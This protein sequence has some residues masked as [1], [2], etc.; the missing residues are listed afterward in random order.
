M[1][2]EGREAL[3]M[4][5]RLCSGRLQLPFGLPKQHF[6]KHFYKDNEVPKAV[7]GNVPEKV[8]FKLVYI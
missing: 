6:D 2:E 1:V 5:T 3:S 8:D 7:E 4:E